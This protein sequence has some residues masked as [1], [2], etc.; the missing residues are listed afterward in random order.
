[1]GRVSRGINGRILLLPL[2]G[3]LALTAV[4]V[5][6][7]RTV[8]NIT[9]AEHQARAR[10]VTEAA[11][12]IVASLEGKASIGEMTTEAAQE[13]AKFL[14]RAIR[15]D[16][17]EYV[18]VRGLDGT[19]IANGMFPEQEGRNAFDQQDANGTH[20]AR[21]SIAAAKTGGGFNSYLWPKS[22][23]APPV[24]KV[25]YSLLSAAWQWD[26]VTGIYMDEV[27]A[28]SREHAIRLGTAIVVLAVVTFGLAFWLGRRISGPILL[29][30]STTDRL[31]HG[32][33]SVEVPGLQ[34]A[35]EIGTLARSIGVLRDRSAEAETLRAN[36]ERMKTAAVQ[37][38]QRR[39]TDWRNV[40]NQR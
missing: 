20:Y 38:R 30:S 29:L 34:R 4:G 11:A 13:A 32:E 35:D 16:R 23:N 27:E 33:P 1:M 39:R 40:W 36:Q 25:S 6:A 5:I 3:L 26:V 24:R 28:A 22:P 31:A 7:I 2:V 10:V 37:E 9:L 14:L 19:I 15:Y 17:T 21:D 12:A 18:L 8:N